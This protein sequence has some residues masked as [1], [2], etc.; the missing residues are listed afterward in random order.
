MLFMLSCL[1]SLFF[2]T[3]KRHFSNTHF[4]FS[5]YACSCSSDQKERREREKEVKEIYREVLW[6]NDWTAFWIFDNNNKYNIIRCHG[7]RTLSQAE[8]KSEVI[9]D[10]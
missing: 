1:R 7:S 4:F 10:M 6:L 3:A 8:K 9:R 2:F 5:S